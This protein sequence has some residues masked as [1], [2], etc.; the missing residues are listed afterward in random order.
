[1]GP[2]GGAAERVGRVSGRW[3]PGLAFAALAALALALF[4]DDLL[5]RPPPA[6]PPRAAAMPYAVL[7]PAGR[8]I[9][10]LAVDWPRHLRENED[11]LVELRY[12]A[13]P[14]WAAAFRASAADARTP[15]K[16]TVRLAA[17]RLSLRP[18]P[19]EHRFDTA[20]IAAAGSDRRSW[21]L[22][23]DKEGDYILLVRLEAE[24]A[25]FEAVPIA[26]AGVAQGGGGEVALPVRVS[27]RYLV[28][29]W[30]VDLARLAASGLAFLL[31]LP[32]AAAWLARRRG[33]KPK[34]GGRRR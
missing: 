11:G 8:R 34:A 26:A 17:A 22:S 6:S 27:T 12:S 29:Q 31:T 15:L 4:L 18:E 23:P 3:W 16:L 32:L 14:G 5:R 25:G 28:P 7:N 10:A 21:I 1:M 9:G 30:A 24:P 2:G 33:A 20:R 19:A 13:A